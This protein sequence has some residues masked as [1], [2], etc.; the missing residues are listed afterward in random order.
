MASLEEIRKERL[1]KLE[2]IKEKGFL[3]Y[4][5]ETNRDFSLVDLKE[6]FDDLEKKEKQVTLAGRV[7]SIRGQGAIMF[8][9][10]DDGTEEFQ[11]VIKK[12][13]MEEDAWTFFDEVVDIG[14]FISATGSLMRTKRGAPSLLLKTWRMLSK[15]LRPLP[16]K[17]HGLTDIEE[18]YR[19]RY[20]DT[21][22]SPESKER[23][24]LRS[25][26]T[27]EIRGFL[28]YAGY[29]EVETPTLQSL[30]GGATAKPFTTHHE[31]LDIDLHLRVAL[32]LFHK[33]LL[34]G[35]FPKVYEIGK[36]VR[37]E[38]IDATHNPEF[39]MLEFYEA[40]ST[41]AAQQDFVEAMIRT[42]V[43]NVF[44]SEPI[45]N[46]YGTINFSEK[47]EEI[48][49]FDL[50]KEHA[51]IDDPDSLT[52]EEAIKRAQELDIPL[53]KGDS[54]EEIIDK[55]Y[56]KTCRP[57]LI[58]PTFITHYPVA[59]SPFAKRSEE[60]PD[61]IDRF[62]LV[63]GGFELVNAFSELNDPIDQKERYEEQDRKRNEGNAE[64]SPSDQDFLEAM[65]YGMPPAGGVGIGIDR[66]VMLLT[67]AQNI[68]EVILFPTLR[69]K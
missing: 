18:K 23:F 2:K 25:K 5:I 10:L 46:D 6:N 7:M 57:K 21:L 16:E 67:G 26:I 49:F 60:N 20:L 13:E 63:A 55:I 15:S 53:E 58:N 35:G 66:L 38:G 48:K 62:Q 68:R 32:E 39:S 29:L 31:A 64:I 11:G 69:P 44:G 61:F 3:A 12:D 43:K 27:K 45:E 24:L 30:A 9:T 52:H 28:D 36:N 17:W 54:L 37:N 8:L 40:Y 41:R 47:F 65:E 56:K 19:R 22:M 50:L 33:R 51:G 42:V 34:I 1:K 4:P 14:D 59:F